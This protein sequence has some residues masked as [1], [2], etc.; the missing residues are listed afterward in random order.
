[1][2]TLHSVANQ[3]IKVK[4]IIVINDGSTDDTLKIIEKEAALEGWIV[5]IRIIDQNNT[6]PGAAR[7][8]AIALASGAYLAFLDADDEWHSTKLARSIEELKNNNCTLIAHDVIHQYPSG[9]KYYVESSKRFENENK[10]SHAEHFLNDYINTSTV[11]V[12]IQAVKAVGGFD[13]I[14]FY[15]LG[16]DLWQAILA[17]KKNTF[18]VF[19][20]ALVT[21]HVNRHSLSSR[22]IKR[23]QCH[24]RYIIRHAKNAAKNSPLPT[25]ILT[26]MKTFKLNVNILKRAKNNNLWFQFVLA[27]LRMP[28]SILKTLTLSAIIP[29]YKRPDNIIK[30]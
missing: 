21:Y 22:I 4:E 23:L 1:M 3:S 12:N 17:N 5:P 24:E 30:N 10:N 6:G 29:T 8:K 20:G 25:C 19:K 15:D 13:E 18:H 28:Y 2:R 16:Y 9:R 7:N 26:L 11:L 14:G 27:L